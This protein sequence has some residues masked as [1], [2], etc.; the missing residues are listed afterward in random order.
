MFE[1][2]RWDGLK[3]LDRWISLALEVIIEKIS[4]SPWSNFSEH[5]TTTLYQ[6][7]QGYS[8]LCILLRLRLNWKPHAFAKQGSWFGDV[9]NQLGNVRNG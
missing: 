2:L 8:G 7:F 9:R 4:E 6:A 3:L 5:P 1:S